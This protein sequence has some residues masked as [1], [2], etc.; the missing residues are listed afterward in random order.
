MVTETGTGDE[1]MTGDGW[2]FS[3]SNSTANNDVFM[4]FIDVLASSDT[5]TFTGVHSSGY[6]RLLFVR[7]RDGG[8]TPIK[9]FESTSAQFLSTPQTIAAVR[10]PD[11]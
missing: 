8:G 4:A 1:V 6:D 7:V 3:G 11:V 5:A 9:T 10:T 2:D